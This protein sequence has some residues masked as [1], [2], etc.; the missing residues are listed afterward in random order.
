M[1]KVI[2]L[3]ALVLLCSIWSV[4][5]SSETKNQEFSIHYFWG[6]GMLPNERDITLKGSLGRIRSVGFSKE[7]RIES[8]CIEANLR[9]DNVENLRNLVLKLKV[10]DSTEEEKGPERIC[11]GSEWLEITIAE[12]TNRYYK[13]CK[14]KW[15]KNDSTI[16]T[17]AD[18]I[19][20]YLGRLIYS[21]GKACKSNN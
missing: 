1:D 10:I 6:A 20:N 8:K 17:Q 12:K 11:E 2:K 21:E 9:K 5:Y 14:E 3:N 13:P 18:S 7:H 4:A 16:S 15:N 19:S